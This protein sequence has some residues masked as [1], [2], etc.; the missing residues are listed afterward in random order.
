[1]YD[2]AL[3]NPQPIIDVD[4][5]GVFETNCSNPQCTEVSYAGG[6][7]VFDVTGFSGFGSNESESEAAQG[8]GQGEAV[9][10]FSEWA[11]MILLGTCIA[12]F[13]YVRREEQ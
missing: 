11:V 6:T 5:D 10:E 9:P 7:F 3:T 4:L 13:F 1:M 2:L 8:G 12:G